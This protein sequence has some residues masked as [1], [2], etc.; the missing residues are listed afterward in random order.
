VG[1][2]KVS[3]HSLRHSYATHLLKQGLSLRHIQALLGHAS[4]AT[5]ARYTHLSQITERDSATTINDLINRLQ[6]DLQRV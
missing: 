5:T 1:L 6:A 4:S 3:L 2:K